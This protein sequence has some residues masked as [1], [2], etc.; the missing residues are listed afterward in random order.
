MLG[1]MIEVIC[2]GELLQPV[3]PGLLLPGPPAGQQGE[4]YPVPDQSVFFGISGKQFTV[5]LRDLPA[6]IE[7]IKRPFDG[8]YTLRLK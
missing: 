8:L 3:Q 1:N 7:G 5:P 4:K 6:I 2:F